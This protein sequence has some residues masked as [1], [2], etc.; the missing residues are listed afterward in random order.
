M[1]NKSAFTYILRRL[2]ALLLVP[3]L[4]ASCT[5]EQQF[6]EPSKTVGVSRAAEKLLASAERNEIVPE[7]MLPV[8]DEQP[9]LDGNTGSADSSASA[10]SGSG[11]SWSFENG[12]YTYT[13]PE[14]DRSTLSDLTD[15]NNTSRDFF[16]D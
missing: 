3:M 7:G 13:V 12:K 14:P 1:N 6:A 16:D 2:T 11:V 5:L 10:G 8:A 9:P 15:V 4:L